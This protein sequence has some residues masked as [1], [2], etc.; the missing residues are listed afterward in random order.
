MDDR[1]K[2]KSMI[3]HV[4]DDPADRELVRET[5]DTEGIGLEL[6]QVDSREAFE[7]ALARD[8]V[9]IVLS[10]FAL[11][12]FDGFSALEIVQKQKP[13]LPFIFVSGTLGEDAAIESL[14]RG[15]TDYVLKQRLSRLG[16]AVRRALEEVAVQ[17]KRAEAAEAAAN[18]QQFL[19]A[20]LESVDAGIVACD[21]TG[22]VTVLNRAARGILGL[23]ENPAPP[24]Q[25]ERYYSLYEPSGRRPLEK[26]AV[27]L[28]RALAG[29]HVRNVELVVRSGNGD[30]RNVLVS[31]QPIRGLQNQSLGAVVAFQDITD[32][33]ALENQLRQSQKLEAVGSLA[34]GVAHDF[35]NLLTVIGGYSQMVMDQIGRNAPHYGAIEEVKKASDRAA[36]LTRQLL[37]FSRSQKLETRILDVNDVVRDMEKMLRRLLPANIE[38]VTRLSPSLGR[39][40]GDPGQIEQVL[41]NLVVN[42]RDAMPEG[43]RLSVETVARS[44]GG[45]VAPPEAGAGPCVLLTISDTGTGMSAEVQARMFE[46]FFTTKEV[47]KGTGLG[48]ST[49]YGIIKQSGG[50]ISVHSEVG[51]G[52]TFRVYLPEVSDAEPA[53]QNL[54]RPTPVVG[55]TE[56][57][58]LVEDDPTVR[59][60]AQQVL[61]TAGYTVLTAG[62]G[63]QALGILEGHFGRVHLVLAD[64]VMPGM[65]GIELL[66]QVRSRFPESKRLSMSGYADRAPGLGSASNVPHIQKPFAPSALMERVREVLDRK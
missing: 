33:K 29:E 57:I 53:T 64:I 43:G 51:T 16:P 54:V 47:G 23:G 5:L 55:G 60:L 50:A 4:E 65:G 30:A 18:R 27:P 56:T 46:P 31:G 42:A 26:E 45:E 19:K 17:R 32:R 2:A 39:I 28:A 66:T 7:A 41:L 38:F 3:L 59:G 49:V 25:W 24:D 35:N 52:T 63:E 11:P 10:D 62:S 14:R 37:A 20:M 61:E 22:A 15:A 34:G 9:E 8:E 12:R 58:L 48:L 6:V 1:A 40:K 13:A 21:A 36:A 44:V